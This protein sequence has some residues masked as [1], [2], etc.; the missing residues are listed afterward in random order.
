MSAQPSIRVVKS[1]T[2]RGSARLWSNRYYF[3]GSKPADNTKWTTFSD[4]V[5]AA[6]KA[7]LPSAQ[8]VTQIVQT[9]GYDAGSD[10]PVFSKTYALTGTFTPSTNLAAPGDAAVYIR[11]S[12][13]GKTS[14]NHPIY[15]YN[16]FHSV[17]MN[18]AT[19][20]DSQLPAQKT[21]LE[22]Y[23]TAWVTGFSD[24]AVTHKRCGPNGDLATGIFVHP[25]ISHRDFPRG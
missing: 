4:A 2:Y 14:K 9:Y 19:G 20:Q 17:I 13:A 11:F 23:G 18:S 7:V 1:F 8:N 24:G 22:T 10:V 15:L 16:Y 25:F 6:E 21:A 12:T 5:T 3:D